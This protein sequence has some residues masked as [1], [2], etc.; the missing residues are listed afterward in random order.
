M[1]WM[2]LS[3]ALF[4]PEIGFLDEMIKQ[5]IIGKSF[6]N[7]KVKNFI[8]FDNL[9]YKRFKLQCSICGTKDGACI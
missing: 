4:V 5:P 6:I 7:N 3:C 1:K 2:H 8:G 9:D